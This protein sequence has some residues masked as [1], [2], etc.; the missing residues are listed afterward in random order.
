MEKLREMKC[1]ECSGNIIDPIKT[2]VSNGELKEV[3]ECESCHDLFVRDSFIKLWDI[4]YNTAH[5]DQSK[6]ETVQQWEERTGETYP[7]DGPVWSC[8]KYSRGWHLQLWKQ[9]K[10]DLEIDIDGSV[11]IEVAV[12]THHGKPE[13]NN[14]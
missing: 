7:D 9:C 13:I 6:H 12:A 8:S 1:P 10:F 11:E 14:G 3:I 5:Q 2:M 4:S